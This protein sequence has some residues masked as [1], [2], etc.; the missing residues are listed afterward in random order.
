MPS[1]S[2][3][4]PC[5]LQPAPLKAGDQVRFISPASSPDRQAVQQRARL[6]ESWGL[7]VSFGK[8]AFKKVGFLAGTDEE[9]V[10]DLNQAFQDTDVRAIF[11]T[12]G[13]KGSYR[14]ADQIDFDAVRRDPKFI[15]GFS[16]IT[17]LHLSL[18]KNCQLVGVHG[19]LLEN[20]LGEIDPENAGLLK[21][22]LMTDDSIVLKADS[23][24]ET[25]AL[26]TRGHAE[27]ILIGGN[28][29]MIATLAGWGLPNL[30]T[31]ILLIEAVNMYPGQVDRMLSSLRK[32]GHFDGLKGIA[33]GQ[34]TGIEKSGTHR[35]IDLLKEH[36]APLNLPILGG[37]PL[38]H[39]PNALSVPVG[40]V[41][42][43]DADAG[44]LIIKRP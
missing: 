4:N 36:F 38:G 14:I 1:S 33:I 3:E 5:I 10:T 20:E 37:I 7:S 42:W 32:S 16:D 8:N 27:G 44:E 12:R 25:A 28:L 29:E 24:E 40:A 13:G 9:R 34:F 15:I 43:L 31:K 17:A 21:H 30:E 2:L 19:A 23:S 6:L 11:A 39:G 22:I 26:T 41:T 18:W 35:I